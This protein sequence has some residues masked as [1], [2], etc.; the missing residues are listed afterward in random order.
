M[1]DATDATTL[2]LAE[3]A[4]PPARCLTD[5]TAEAR[6]SEPQSI[7]AGFRPF[8]RYAIEL[9]QPAGGK[10]RFMRDILR[11]GATVGV[12]AVDLAR[13]EIVVIRQFR[14]AAQLGTGLGDLVEIPAGYVDQGE[15]PIEAARR[16]CIEEIG[17]APRALQE[18]YTFLPAPGILDE[19]AT[20]YI[21]AVDASQVPA[22]A[23]AADETEQTRPL[24]VRIDDALD[25]LK[26]GSIHNGYLI[27]ALQWLALNRERL[28][29]W[30]G[31]A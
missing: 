16:E 22:N 30:L 28:P 5:R 14:L 17:I 13:D 19:H 11:V 29:E 25:A 4:A 31:G 3:R 24:R 12:I 7:G 26:R 21:A 6:I 1:A 20:I 23:G 2:T 9:A 15:T 8:E 10:T 27:M 18:I